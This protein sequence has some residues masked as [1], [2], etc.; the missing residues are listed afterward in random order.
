MNTVYFHFRRKN[1][2]P[3]PTKGDPMRSKVDARGGVTACVL[4]KPRCKYAI[5]I[6]LSICSPLDNYQKEKGRH[7]ALAKTNDPKNRFAVLESG[8][9][10]N[11]K[12]RSL[13]TKILQ[14]VK[15]L[16]KVK[17]TEIRKRRSVKQPRWKGPV[18]TL[19]PGY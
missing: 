8:D 18:P 6:G 11:F 17:W 7:E 13:Q 9:S 5:R 19:F 2:D 16:V 14:L 3:K 1:T 10:L 12:N 4:I 15:G